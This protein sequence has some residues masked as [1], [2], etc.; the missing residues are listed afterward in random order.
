MP[1]YML[2]LVGEWAAP[3]WFANIN[4]PGDQRALEEVL[5]RRDRP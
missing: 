5:A 2:R 1:K 3:E 4:A